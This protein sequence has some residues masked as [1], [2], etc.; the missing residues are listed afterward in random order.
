MPA[1]YTVDELIDQVRDQVDESNVE[2]VSDADIL[3][4]LNRAQRR[5][6]NILAR[7][8]ENF[9]ITFTSQ[10]TELG[11]DTYPIPEVAYGRRLEQ[12]TIVRNKLEYPLKRVGYRELYRF[13]SGAIVSIPYVYAIKGRDYIIKPTPQSGT[14]LKIWYMAAPETL[15]VNQGRITSIDDVNLSVTLDNVGDG[16]TTSTAELGAFVNIVDAST[17]AIKVTLQ[18]AS[19]NKASRTVTFK[20]A[21]LTFDTVYNRI[22]SVE[23]PETA[24]V[25]RGD[26]LCAVAGTS[27]P[28]LPDAC[29]DYLVQFAVV[30]VRRRMGEPTQDDMVALRD[31]EQDL[32]RQWAGRELVS[33]V[34]NKARSWVR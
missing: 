1:P 12:I 24:G 30:E 19:I 5:A 13:A 29:L 33:R 17:G 9:F 27:V 7:Q 2:D 28:D 31:Q 14:E 32:T 6:A 11:K 26:Y 18:I 25:D 34:S 23:I 3:Q 16:L 8:D 22:V 4:A 21:G 10:V 15:V 20:T